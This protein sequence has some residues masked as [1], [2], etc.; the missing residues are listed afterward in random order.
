MFH[1]G[2]N[3]LVDRGLNVVVGW[4]WCVCLGLEEYGMVL[5]VVPLNC[6]HT[7]TVFLL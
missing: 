7:V 2:G 3:D 1:C 4:R 5:E 6:W